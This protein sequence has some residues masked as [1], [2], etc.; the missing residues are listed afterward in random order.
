MQYPCATIKTEF[1]IQQNETVLWILA[2]V[3]NAAW[4]IFWCSIRASCDGRL[5]LAHISQ[6]LQFQNSPNRKRML[7]GPDKHFETQLVE[8]QDF[9]EYLTRDYPGSCVAVLIW[10]TVSILLRITVEILWLM[11]QKHPWENVK[12]QLISVF[13]VHR[14]S[15]HYEQ[16]ERCHSQWRTRAKLITHP[17]SSPQICGAF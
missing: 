9:E 4:L 16:S 11:F 1:A 10:N 5:K 7:A 12:A 8:T 2:A 6:G 3:Q 14:G 13:H 15:N 17:F